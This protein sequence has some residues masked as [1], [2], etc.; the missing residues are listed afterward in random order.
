MRK[1]RSKD[2]RKRVFIIITVSI[3]AIFFCFFICNEVRAE[4]GDDPREDL[5]PIFDGKADPELK[6]QDCKGYKDCPVDNWE[7]FIPKFA[8][9]RDSAIEA[10]RKIKSK[11]VTD[12]EEVWNSNRTTVYITST[13]FEYSED[14]ALYPY[15]TLCTNSH[16]FE[17]WSEKPDVGERSCWI[18]PTEVIFV[19]GRYL[20]KVFVPSLNK[21]TDYVRKIA[22]SIADKL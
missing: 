15:T 8:A 9:K 18:S 2:M 16:E 3:C 14:A 19:K 7:K 6:F 4:A 20:V 11:K 5:S 22:R 12:R 17:G 13:Y 1:V 10:A 21:C